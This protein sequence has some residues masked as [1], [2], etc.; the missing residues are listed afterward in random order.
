MGTNGK[1]APVMFSQEEI[2]KLA[3]DIDWFIR[4]FDPHHYREV[5]GD[6]IEKS[7]MSV[8]AI[9]NNITNED[10]YHIHKYLQG[11][12]DDYE[13]NPDFTYELELCRALLVRLNDATDLVKHGKIKTN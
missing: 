3:T 11:I 1:N 6:K 10:I 5:F 7:E 13:D 12:I 4:R 8:E 2:Y 9:A